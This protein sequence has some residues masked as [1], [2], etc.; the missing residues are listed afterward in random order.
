MGTVIA[1]T[2]MR[3]SA[4]SKIMRSIHT[5]CRTM[6]Y[7]RNTYRSTCAEL[8]G[9]AD[10]M[11]RWTKPSRAIYLRIDAENILYSRGKFSPAAR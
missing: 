11:I 3:N 9:S 4:A 1:R 8:T 5:F 10:S 7:E 6:D 2:K